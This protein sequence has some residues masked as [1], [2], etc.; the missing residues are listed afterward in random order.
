M[1]HSLKRLDDFSHNAPAI[2]ISVEPL[3]DSLLTCNVFDRGFTINQA[4]ENHRRTYLN[5]LLNGGD[6]NKP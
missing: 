5:I 4:T 3:D 1:F 2:R 6:L